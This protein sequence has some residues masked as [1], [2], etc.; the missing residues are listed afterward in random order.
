MNR[1]LVNLMFVIGLLFVITACVCR[2]DRDKAPKSSK[3]DDNPVSNSGRPADAPTPA[4]TTT[5]IK[6]EGDFT[7]DHVA[8]TNPKYTEIDR[9]VR[10][11][12]LLEKAA[13]QL[14]RSLVLPHDIEL[15]TKVCG[16]VNA[17]YDPADPSVTVCYELMEHFYKV[18]RSG[19]A[20]SA[21]AYDKMFDAV[22]FV[23][24]H[25]IG[26]ALIDTYKLPVTGNEEDA[27]DRCSAYV[28]L[29][30]LGDDG[31][32]AVFAAA[33]A[34]QIESKQGSTDQHDMAD[35]HLLQE[36]R[37]YNSL[38]MIYG[39][40]PSKYSNIFTEGYLPKERAVRC[41]SEYQRT[42]DSWRNLLAPWRKN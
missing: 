4:T 41:E 24:L 37:F 21:K 28:N 8:V 26:H 39:S 36:Q 12:Q 34:F 13:D 35:E 15:R 17:F 3:D 40:N 42:S 6:D 20:S 23:F 11:E 32:K 14:N 29:E 2:S 10:N 5:K 22:R 18:F 31:V 38:C 1:N 7:V 30:E 19:G 25:E 33:E 9:E 27:A 16:E